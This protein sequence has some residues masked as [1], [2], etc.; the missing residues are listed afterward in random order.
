MEHA[1]RQRPHNSPCWEERQA[2][3]HLLHE[4]YAC[5]PVVAMAGPLLQS[6]EACAHPQM[7]DEAVDAGRELTAGAAQRL[8]ICLGW[9]RGADGSERCSWQ[10]W[11]RTGKGGTSVRRR[12]APGTTWLL[13]HVEYAVVWQRTGMQTGR[14][15]PRMCEA[16]SSFLPCKQ[17]E[18]GVSS[19]L[20]V[21]IRTCVCVALHHD[22]GHMCTSCSIQC[23]KALKEVR[24]ASKSGA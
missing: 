19:H 1:Q 21:V 22:L 17:P 10:L 24:R 4:R 16:I 18:Q 5:G 6:E 12:A 3:P 11:Q 9:Q 8:L 15:L 20:S 2:V 23:R 13:R 14:A 7:A